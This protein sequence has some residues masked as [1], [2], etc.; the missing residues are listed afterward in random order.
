[1]K[2]RGKHLEF[3]LVFIIKTM[4]SLELFIKLRE[5]S[6]ILDLFLVKIYNVDIQLRYVLSVVY[7]GV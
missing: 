2:V 6:L 3:S 1:M 4:Q 7:L 5:Q